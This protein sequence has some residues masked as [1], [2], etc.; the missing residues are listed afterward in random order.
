MYGRILT[1]VYE[2]GGGREMNA[3]GLMTALILLICAA[4]VLY[5]CASD[6]EE[7]ATPQAEILF[8][9]PFDYGTPD[10]DLSSITGNWTQFRTGQK[11]TYESASGLSLAGYSSGAGGAVRLK[12]DSFNGYESLERSFEPQTDGVLYLGFLIN[13]KVGHGYAGTAVG[14]CNEGSIVAGFYCIFPMSSPYIGYCS[15]TG[16]Q[17]TGI[18]LYAKDATKLVVMR[19]DLDNDTVAFYNN[20]DVQSAKP[21]EP[22]WSR[23]YSGGFT[24]IDGVFLNHN[25][26]TNELADPVKP[27]NIVDEIKVVTGW[28]ALVD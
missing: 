18:N 10:G 6:G 17:A 28:E 26:I 15:P 9:E 1:A 3:R 20:P 5:S 11:I 7:T 24:Q 25:V 19:A 12:A 8:E 27:E 13:S 2:K 22:D 21:P 4:L 16:G 14:L 23:S